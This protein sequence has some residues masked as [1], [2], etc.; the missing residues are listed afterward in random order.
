MLSLWRFKNEVQNFVL[1]S[2]TNFWRSRLDGGLG[3]GA[4]QSHSPSPNPIL[5]RAKD[6]FQLTIQKKETEVSLRLTNFVLQYVSSINLAAKV[7]NF[8][9]TAKKDPEKRYRLYCGVQSIN[10]PYS[11]LASAKLAIWRKKTF[12][13]ESKF[14]GCLIINVNSR[15]KITWRILLWIEGA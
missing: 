5:S 8:R 13:G 12:L 10:T 6:Y 9:L 2:P 14:R 4:S 15:P 3:D 11:Q 1:N 7:A